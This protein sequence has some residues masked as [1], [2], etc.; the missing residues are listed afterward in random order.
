MGTS[1]ELDSRTAGDADVV[2]RTSIFFVA[3]AGAARAVRLAVGASAELNSRTTRDAD[4][5][6]GTGIVLAVASGRSSVVAL[7]TTEK[8]KTALVCSIS[9]VYL[10]ISWCSRN[11]VRVVGTYQL[12]NRQHRGGANGESKAQ[13]GREG[14]GLGRHFRYCGV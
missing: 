14:E 1:A 8:R 6:T 13:S 11:D 3:H 2:A 4:V 7:V 9:V 12:G 5:E 10:L